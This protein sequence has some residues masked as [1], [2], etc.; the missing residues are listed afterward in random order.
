MEVILS[1]GLSLYKP[2]QNYQYIYRNII[3]ES[4]LIV[5]KTVNASSNIR[6][7]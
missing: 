1:M 4:G 5:K 7:I 2:I 6:L 3:S